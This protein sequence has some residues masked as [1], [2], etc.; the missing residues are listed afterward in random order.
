MEVP[1][2]PSK[3]KKGSHRVISRKKNSKGVI[4]NPLQTHV[5]SFASR[6]PE[7]PVGNA[8]CVYFR[9]VKGRWVR[10]KRKPASGSFFCIADHHQAATPVIASISTG[11]DAFCQQC[12]LLQNSNDSE[13]YTEL[14]NTTAYEVVL[15][16]FAAS[17]AA[18]REEAFACVD[19]TNLS[20]LDSEC[21]EFL[22]SMEDSRAQYNLHCEDR[23]Q[24]VSTLLNSM[25]LT[26]TSE[27]T[28]TRIPRSRQTSRQSTPPVTFAAGSPFRSTVNSDD[29]DVPGVVAQNPE[30][31]RISELE[32]KLKAAT[33]K[34]AC[35]EFE[36]EYNKVESHKK[37]AEVTA[38]LANAESR[39]AELQEGEAAFQ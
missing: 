33:E 5:P 36:L 27:T 20:E 17:T 25:T 3:Y 14:C 2:L 1:T 30:L 10:C 4:W 9:K 15:K 19:V 18:D 22:T 24:A 29:D 6:D 23:Q 32:S 16:C 38:E 12:D 37:L 34:I 31:T 13:Y 21:Q 35:L 39:I 11:A 7:A 28:P 26:S 8:R